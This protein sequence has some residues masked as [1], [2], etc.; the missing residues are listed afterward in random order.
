M[1]SLTSEIKASLAWLWQDAS[2][3]STISDGS[4][5]DYVLPFANGTGDAEV[6]LVWHDEKSLA[7]GAHDDL[8]LSALAR[9]LFGDTLN[10]EMASVKAI[11]LV[12]LATTDG[13]NLEVGGAATDPWPGPFATPA[14]KLV[15]PADSCLLLVNK[16]AGWPV[17]PGSADRLRITN[18]GTGEVSYKIAVLGTS[19]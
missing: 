14:D 12:N 10:V 13:E 6:D 3:L 2:N 19:A 15:I 1:T 9:P 16:N 8:V 18:A 7:I 17:A 4:R 11:L 5:L